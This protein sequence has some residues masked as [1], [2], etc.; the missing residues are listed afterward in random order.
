MQTHVIEVG[1][2]KEFFDATGNST[3]SDI[4]EDLLIDSVSEV[5]Y[6]ELFKIKSDLSIEEVKKIASELCTDKVVQ[7]FSLNED[8]RKGFDW[9]I[10][11]NF[12]ADV[13]DNIGIIAKEGIQDL[14]E[15]DVSV[16]TA[17]K[18]YLKGSLTESDAKKIGEG[19]L[20]N[21]IIEDFK[22]LKGKK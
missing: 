13:T 1:Y 12:H 22:A 7:E 6:S 15:K 17:R 9:I 11:V 19:L 14:L 3:L 16:R 2:K 21:S 20:A 4:K 8:L 5:K 18:Y 10:E